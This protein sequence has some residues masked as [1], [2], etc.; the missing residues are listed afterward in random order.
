MKITKARQEALCCSSRIRKDLPQKLNGSSLGLQLH[1][2]G[3]F[4]QRLM[5][6]K[7]NSIHEKNGKKSC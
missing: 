3:T 4:F 6:T 1:H 5:T 7:S 2:E